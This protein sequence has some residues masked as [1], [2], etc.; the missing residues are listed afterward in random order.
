MKKSFVVLFVF[1]VVITAAV[2]N[3]YYYIPQL[4]VMFLSP[5]L[6]VR[7]GFDK[8]DRILFFLMLSILMTAFTHPSVFRLST[9]GYSMLFVTTYM[10]YGK[11]FSKEHVDIS[12]FQ[13]FAKGIIIAY[14]V[15]L[16]VQISSRLLGIPPINASY[17]T[18]EGLKLNSLSYEASQIGATITIFMY[19]YIKMEEI[20]NGKKFI[21][22]QLFQG[23]VKKVFI[24]YVVTI[25]FSF[26][27]TCYLALF[28]FVLYFVS[29]KKI[30]KGSI[31]VFIGLIIFFSIGTEIGDR[32][33]VVMSALPSMDVRMLYEADA[34]ASARIVPLIV[35]FQEFN[36]F[37]IDLWLGHGCDYGNLHIWRILMD[38]DNAEGSM[39]VVGIFGF[40]YDYGLIAFLI[41]LN[42]IHS[43]CKFKS[44]EFLLYMTLFFISGFNEHGTWVFFM[45]IYAINYF[46]SCQIKKYD[47]NHHEVLNYTEK[48]NVTKTKNHNRLC[49]L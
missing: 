31:V 39:A 23:N 12:G 14:A 15:V 30:V 45:V 2:V 28:I 34:S 48:T 21:F 20:K 33:L 32:I 16:L 13:G 19:A 6:L 9:V 5:F 11:I 38:D 49:M 3:L 43:L 44:F 29:L 1:C 26:S 7:E 41:F 47:R 36:L 42:F 4:I 35:F 8:K 17:N 46:N 22:L 25:F 10:Y 40:I 18:E 37:S 27:V 24:S